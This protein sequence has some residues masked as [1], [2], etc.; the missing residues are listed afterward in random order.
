[1]ARYIEFPT[2]KKIGRLTVIKQVGQDKHGSYLW[3]CKCDCGNETIATGSHLLS[4]RTRSCGCF[5]RDS[6]SK[7]QTTHGM[8]D[9]RL[10]GIWSTMKRR[11][12]NPKVESYRLYGGRGISVC[13]EWER[14]EPF[15]DWSLLNGYKD[16][17]SIDRIDNDKGYSPDNCKWSTA[18]EIGRAHV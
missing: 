7:R 8:T 2:G 12:D 16:G 4:K 13:T 18:K 1:M 15:R 5:Q 11:C 14:F 6:L 10:Y 9:S 17:L 3:L